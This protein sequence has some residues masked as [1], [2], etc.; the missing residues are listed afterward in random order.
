MSEER[1]T[2]RGCSYIELDYFDMPCKECIRCYPRTA[3]TDKFTL[4]QEETEQE[5][6]ELESEQDDHNILWNNQK[7]MWCAIHRLHNKIDE[8][9]PNILEFKL[10]EPSEAEK[11]ERKRHNQKLEKIFTVYSVVLIVIL[12][13][14]WFFKA[15]GLHVIQRMVRKRLDR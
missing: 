14:V 7:T 6:K 2:C 15:G 11:A 13:L 10:P 3:T 1:P 5:I 9:T 4:K 8:Q 12:I